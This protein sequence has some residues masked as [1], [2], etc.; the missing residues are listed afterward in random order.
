MTLGEMSEENRIPYE[1]FVYEMD[2]GNKRSVRW[3]GG[4]ESSFALLS[5]LYPC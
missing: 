2:K 1:I 5:H 3:E 4:Y